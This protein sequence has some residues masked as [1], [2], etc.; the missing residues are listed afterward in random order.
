MEPE[1]V[2]VDKDE[3]SIVSSGTT[4]LR[5]E[6]SFNFPHPRPVLTLNDFNFICVRSQIK[7]RF[8]IR[9]YTFIPS[10]MGHYVCWVW[11]DLTV[12]SI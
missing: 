7:D 9:I 2:G 5:S 1:W 12:T 8:T 4:F 10:E 3:G 11:F 6:V